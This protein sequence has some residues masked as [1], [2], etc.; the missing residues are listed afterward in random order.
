MNDAG[1]S[2]QQKHALSE[3]IER[4]F[5]LFFPRERFDD[6][7]RSVAKA[8]V[9]SGFEEVASYTQWLLSGQHAEKQL[10]PL[11]TNLTI[12]ETY[13]FRDGG[14]F[15]GLE[16]TV[17]PQI[18]AADSGD[19][20]ARIWSAACSTGEEAYSLAILLDQAN[21][22]PADWQLELHATDINVKS[23]AKARS[24]TYSQWSFRGV[25]T[26]LKDSY[27]NRYDHHSWQLKEHIRQ[28]V[29]FSCVN[30]A[31]QPFKVGSSARQPFD[32]PFDLILCR[33]VL[34]Y[35]SAQLRS[36]I[37]HGL[38]AML[39]D[40]GWLVVSPSEVGLVDVKQLSVVDTG[41]M[42]MHRK[43]LPAAKRKTPESQT[44]PRRSSSV[45]RRRGAIAASFIPAGKR[46][47]AA[48]KSGDGKD[49]QAL[50]S[51]D[52]AAAATTSA[53]T[54]FDRAKQLAERRAYAEAADMLRPCVEN[55]SA[56]TI[57][58]G[59]AMLL[60]GRCLANVGQIE[61][62]QHWLEQG[63]ELDRLN[64]SSYYLL[65]TVQQ[66]QGD[67]AAAQKSLEQAL[68]LEPDYI[69]ANFLLGM[70]LIQQ[71]SAAQKKSQGKKILQRVR[72]LLLKMDPDA[73]VPDSEQLT[74]AHLLNMV[75]TFLG[76]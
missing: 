64:S 72:Q 46:K 13:F 7:L 59:P 43:L 58:R 35:F 4:L 52:L 67:L 41:A 22:F 55:L 37:L 71:H 3:L 48:I 63:L 50:E 62:A 1:L 27:F 10:E 21:P 57:E 26:Q 47:V 8:A 75:E 68:Y 74:V 42:L 69:M 5:G 54:L 32:R 24:A 76:D 45:T 16:E 61:Q 9:E 51:R 66:E 28:M 44:P 33:N 15:S 30:L 56:D 19:K 23:L 25:S 39:K 36:H 2:L 11:I 49:S 12:G 18:V 60:L 31:R 73:M 17:F 14:L 38:T 20:T 70:M 34:M 40:G 53:T 29:K 6:M 65:A